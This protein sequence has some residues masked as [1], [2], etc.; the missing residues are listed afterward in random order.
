MDKIT[1]PAEVT[2]AARRPGTGKRRPQKGRGTVKT[3]PYGAPMRRVGS[4]GRARKGRR[5]RAGLP[6]LFSVSQ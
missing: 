2:R 4:I 1:N 6:I 5:E 3:V